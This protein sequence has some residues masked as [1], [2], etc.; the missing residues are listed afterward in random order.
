M[1]PGSMRRNPVIEIISYLLIFLFVYTATSKLLDY[2]SFKYLLTKSPLIGD[3]AA[4]A[5]LALPI[6]EG[7]VA[8]LLFIPRTRLWGLYA[9]LAL[10]LVSTVYLAYMIFF[11]PGLSWPCGGVLKQITLTQHLLFNIIFTLLSLT[12]IVLMRQ[13]RRSK[14]EHELPPV[15]FT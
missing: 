10:V 15:V 9:S 1:N 7:L 6:T 14:K 4:V 8:L 5:A 2:T 11:T 3:A 12:G 13:E